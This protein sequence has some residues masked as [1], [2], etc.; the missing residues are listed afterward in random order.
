MK[1]FR[2]EILKK[3]VLLA[4]LSVTLSGTAFALPQNGQV[5]AGKGTIAQNGTTMTINQATQ[6]MGVNWNSYNIAKNETVKYQQPNA[7]SIALNRV[8]G[9]NP[10]S[11]YGSL[12][13]NGRVFLINPNGVMFGKSASVNVGGIVASTKN[14]T[15]A[16]FMAGKY[17]F[18]GNSDAKVTNQGTITAAPGGYV[19]F[20]ANNEANEGKITAP[21]GTVA[22]G[23]GNAFTLS[24][25]G[26]GKINLAVDQV[27]ANAAA[28]NSGSIK[29][30]GGY[31]VMHAEDAATVIN[32]VVA[33]TGIIQA[34][35]LKNNK[36]EIVLE[37]G[38]RGIVNAGG[39]MDVSAADGNTDGGNLT[40]KG[41]YTN[42]NKDAQLLAKATGT[43]AG[44][45]IETSGDYLYVDKDA[46]INAASEQGQSGTW[47]LDPLYVLIDNETGAGAWTG[48][49]DNNSD[50]ASTS[51]VSA[52]SIVATLNQGTNVSISATDK[53][54]VA[55]ITVNAAIAKT[56]GGDAALTL[57]A[58]RDI[59]VNAPISSTSGKLNMTFWSDAET[60][61]TA[62]GVGAVVINADLTSNGGNIEMGSGASI[63]T[64]TVGTY[65]GLTTAEFNQLINAVS[66]G[67]INDSNKPKRTITTKGGNFNIYGD[68]LLGIGGQTIVDTTNG[69]AGGDFYVSGKVDSGNFYKKYDF[70]STD[71]KNGTYT[72]NDARKDAYT[73][74]FG[75]TTSGASGLWDSYLANI[76]SSL[77][78][79]IVLSTF[80]KKNDKDSYYIGA[81]A[82]DVANVMKNQAGDDRYWYWTDGPEAGKTFYHQTG[83]GTGTA[84]SDYTYN[85]WHSGEPNNDT[86]WTHGQNVATVGYG[87][88]SYWDDNDAGNKN[89][90]GSLE[91][92]GYIQETNNLRTGLT[93]NA[94]AGNVVFGGDI[95]SQKTLYALNVNNTG[96]VTTKGTVTL[97]GDYFNGV[98]YGGDMDIE[99]TGT[100]TMKKA[101]SATGHIYIGQT[102]APQAVIA[103]DTLTAGGDSTVRNA[104][105]RNIKIGTET[106]RA[107]SVQL[108]KAATADDGITIYT[109]GNV[110]ANGLT[111]KGLVTNGDI[112]INDSGAESKITLKGTT[113][114]TSTNN[115]RD[116]ITIYGDKMELAGPV[117]TNGSTG[118]VTLSNYTAGNSIDLGSGVDTT[119]HT[120]E[121]S[122][123]EV[124]K[125]TAS[126]L[127]VGNNTTGTAT[128]NINVT[129]AIAP[130]GTSV[131]HMYTGQDGT[132]AETGTGTLQ[133]G[134]N[135]TL[136]LAVTAAG[137][138]NLDNA[139]NITTF[140]A[141]STNATDGTI[142]LNQG[143]N[144]LT[145]G[146]VDGLTGVTTNVNSPT[147]YSGVVLATTGSFVNNAGA[148]GIKTTGTNSYWR[149]FSKS[150]IGDKFG[151][152]DSTYLK[153][154]SYADWT[155]TYAKGDTVGTE[156]I[157]GTPNVDDAHNHYIFMDPKTI[158][159]TPYDQTKTYGTDLTK[160]TAYTNGAVGTNVAIVSDVYD[161]VIADDRQEV[162]NALANIKLSSTGFAEKANAG[163]YAGTADG[164]LVSGANL[165]T[166]TTNGYLIKIVPGTLT[167]TTIPLVINTSGTREY[168]A[169]KTGDTFA[170]A[171]Y[172]VDDAA[173]AQ[174][175]GLKSWDAAAY[176]SHINNALANLNDKTSEQLNVG[177]YNDA[178]SYLTLSDS[179]KA[180]DFLSNYTVTYVDTY[181]VNPAELVINISGS[182]EYG[183]AKTGDT[184]AS[185]TYKVDNAATAQTNGLKSWDATAYS[186]HIN[187]N[188]ANLKDQTSEQLNAGSY[189]DKGSYVTLSDTAKAAAFLSN[190]K[191]TYK[192]TYEVTP[193][194]L[195]INLSGDRTY[196]AAKTGDT[197]TSATY[198]V[199]DAATAQT[200]G[201]KSWD[202]AAYNQVVTA[203]ALNDQ[204]TSKLNAGSYSDNGSYL[205]LNDSAKGTNL[206]KNY[207][208]TYKDTYNVEKTPLDVTVTGTREY[209]DQS[210]T[211]VGDYQVTV[212]DGQLKNNETVTP[213]NPTGVLTNTVSATDNVGSYYNNYDGAANT[214]NK[215]SV[216]DILLGGNGF[217]FANYTI[218]YHTK[219]DVTPA[220]LTITADSKS[221][222]QGDA[223]PSLT[224]TY[225]GFK[226]NDGI[227]DVTDR[228]LTTTGTASSLPGG[229]PINFAGHPYIQNYKITLIP[230]TL[231]IESNGNNT[232]NHNKPT[233][234]K[235]DP[236]P[237][238]NQTTHEP[239]VPKVEN[240]LLMGGTNNGK[241]QGWG[242][243]RIKT[244]ESMPVYLVSA[245]GITREGAYN[246]S[247]NETGVKLNPTLNIVSDPQDDVTE[248][249]S[250]VVRYTQEKLSGTFNV[251][252]DGSIVKLTPQDAAANEMIKSNES[253]RYVSLFKGAL[254]S[255][256]D[257]M[258]VVLDSIKAVYLIAK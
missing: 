89:S 251:V 42:V 114:T 202:A 101:V 85:N 104:A 229:Y 182:R 180:A 147:K 151:T 13:A 186:S 117:T 57:K 140:A 15:D 188:L 136:N 46:T 217:D 216:Q 23:A 37:G 20:L 81:H 244:R 75:T 169:T 24:T 139:N 9:N 22:L 243:D 166:H 176:N 159:I 191:V 84:G 27:A 119:A 19:A 189:S 103:N 149:V 124:N 98:Q 51:H 171:T 233:P 55:D 14:I 241:D 137:S 247:E 90:S 146:T 220:P 223:M 141:V 68:L 43:G 87:W 208:V 106:T 72:W 108:D 218:T 135:N 236:T 116:D 100:V 193:T 86:G 234:P 128:K 40:V 178:G 93:V 41:L 226:N 5:T 4:M 129:G 66:S 80:T 2:Y 231:I 12:Q 48:S 21:K 32:S 54:N 258:G 76:T 125:I 227:T 215:V 96:N 184:F 181:T 235:N 257:D 179:A 154:G 206:I 254:N 157:M 190:Y 148:N 111:A 173:T 31:V 205:T 200:N 1:K 225:K 94:A 252:F 199:D 219:Y 230:G 67:D 8:T 177:T 240:P 152:N 213:T 195:T 70:T 131:V 88:N 249:R 10:S 105:D 167:V 172:K 65:I 175:N 44:G 50:S 60:D 33:N 161:T 163:T 210:S 174:T 170:S 232:D 121:L 201:L 245:K 74:S 17:N 198:K 35:S 11:I 102:V 130:T 64:G 168:G 61:T 120:L 92:K 253:T 7:G 207:T 78:N 77:E 59:T 126:K 192:D 143:S 16:N 242:T 95:G 29:A 238:Q 155:T 63:T 183:A 52:A 165:G 123:D 160:N 107:A 246:V 209:G 3:Q 144:T 187:N 73:N 134:L 203:S 224:S 145:I 38:G 122:S 194:A 18:T 228:G 69:T 36:G 185:A 150:P 109:A 79:S 212:K 204:T 6:K 156:D 34:K 110:T 30:D 211:S 39:T 28:V 248:H 25:D 138:V 26:T 56:A 255:A 45:S 162:A 115:D 47:S 53:N 58:E 132:I 197:F 239:I 237:E 97:S 62:N 113:T 153:S 164:I 83:N 127:V 214:G 221:M 158:V 49:Y 256:L 142:R 99:S 133:G 250:I 71:I 82:G 112:V 222:M 118:V 91:M 196:G